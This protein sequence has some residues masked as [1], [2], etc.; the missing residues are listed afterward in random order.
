MDRSFNHCLFSTLGPLIISNDGLRVITADTSYSNDTIWEGVEVEKRSKVPNV[1]NK[2]P[3]FDVGNGSRGHAVNEVVFEFHPS[4]PRLAET[5][6][7]GVLSNGEEYDFTLPAPQSMNKV[8]AGSA[9]SVI[10]HEITD[11]WWA[12]SILQDGR[13][14]LTKAEGF[15]CTNR[16]CEVEW[17]HEK[18]TERQ[19]LSK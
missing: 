11:G 4:E 2:A 5:N 9:E 6:F 19:S 15:N 8:D 14:L 16:V 10:G 3:S 12:R 18:L 17:A 1:K 13:L 7:H